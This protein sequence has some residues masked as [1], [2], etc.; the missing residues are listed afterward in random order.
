MLGED[1]DKHRE[2]DRMATP[3]VT[4]YLRMTDPDDKFPTLVRGDEDPSMVCLL[5]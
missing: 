4:S 1:E 3:D 5:S 2:E